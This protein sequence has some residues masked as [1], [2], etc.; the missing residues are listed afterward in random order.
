MTDDIMVS[1]RMLTYNH[2][3]YVEKAIKSVLMQQVDFNYELVIGDDASTDNTAE[4]IRKYSKEYPDII[5]AVIRTKN[6]GASENSYQIRKMCKGKFVAI[7][8]GDDYWTDENKL[9]KQ[10]D[11]LLDNPNYFSVAHRHEIVDQN[12]NKIG[13]SLEGMTEDQSF[14]KSQAFEYGPRLFHPNSLVHYN[15][16]KTDEPINLF[17]KEAN[18]LGSHSLLVYF[19][20][21]QS[22][23]F[24]FEKPMSVWRKV[25]NKETSNYT[26]FSRYNPL[27]VAR[28]N[29][30]KYVNYRNFFEEEYDFDFKIRSN[31]LRYLLALIKSKQRIREKMKALKKINKQ[32]KQSDFF[33]L[34]QTFFKMV[35]NRLK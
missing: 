2:E 20:A 35:A 17:F 10:V 23:I 3:K 29:V 4:I 21:A 32:M 13:I 15:I 14:D 27:P 9:Q 5:K 12:E 24:V 11:F 1:I 31:Y 33:F 34:P 30:E 7:L 22:N 8:E 6:V 16:F 18:K 19:L 26:S 25:I 28:N